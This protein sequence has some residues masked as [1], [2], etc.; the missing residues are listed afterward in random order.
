MDMNR[1]LFLISLLVGLVV[2]LATAEAHQQ[3]SVLDRIE[4]SIPERE[5]G[6]RLIKDETYL[7]TEVDDFPQAAISW[8]NG[9]EEV[10]AYIVVY[11]KSEAPKEL[12]SEIIKRR[13]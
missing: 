9:I 10:T 7:R 13:M 5:A 11:R 2:V 4:H 8:T 12:S 6:W 1:N 3:E